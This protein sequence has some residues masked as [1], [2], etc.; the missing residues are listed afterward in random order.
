MTGMSHR[1]EREQGVTVARLLGCEIEAWKLCVGGVEKC[2]VK[3]SHL[4]CSSLSKCKKTCTRH[5]LMKYYEHG[6][7]AGY[8]ST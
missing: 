7:K 8:A 3:A 4:K 5:I 6:G 2:D 1:T